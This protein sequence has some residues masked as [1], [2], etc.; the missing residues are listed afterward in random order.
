MPSRFQRPCLD[1]GT[2]TLDSR[3]DNCN[4][5]RLQKLE[6]SE[7]HQA[8][9]AARRQRK[10]ILYS[11]EYQKRS[12]PIRESASHCYLCGEP[13]GAARQID[14]VFPSMLNESPL[15]PTHPQC[16]QKKSG[17]DYDPNE[18]SDGIEIAKL[19]FPVRLKR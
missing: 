17:R 14:H 4:R 13:L 5:K 2:L 15:A 9:Q 7:S 18:W 6:R 11:Y 12:K 10:S 3:C 1:C 16:N 19:Y 8:R